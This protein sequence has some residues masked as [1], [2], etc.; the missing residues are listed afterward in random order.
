MMSEMQEDCLSL[1][2]VERG[3]PAAN[4]RMQSVSHEPNPDRRD[5]AISIVSLTFM[6]VPSRA[7]L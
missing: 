3:A 1:N 2:A 5:A 7:G 4:D 6:D